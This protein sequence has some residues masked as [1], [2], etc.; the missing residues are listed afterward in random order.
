MTCVTYSK[1]RVDEVDGS[2]VGS[3]GASARYLLASMVSNASQGAGSS[4]Q[5]KAGAKML[6][7]YF[8]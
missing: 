3:L 5:S 1:Y 2:T 7:I 4:R 6:S 8:K